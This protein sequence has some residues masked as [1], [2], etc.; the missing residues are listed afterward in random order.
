[1]RDLIIATES[2]MLALG[3]YLGGRV[4]PG[5]LLFLFGE[6]GVGK[7]TLAKGIANSLGVAETVTSPTFQLRKTYRGTMVFNHLDLYRI[8]REAELD[9][10]EPEEWLED[11]VTVVEWGQL[12]L[13]RLGQTYLEIM[14]EADPDDRRHIRFIAHGQRY[15]E[16]I[17]GVFDA[18]LGD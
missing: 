1:M 15:F 17:E 14:I 13:R 10:L 18:D 3:E 5:D 9:I 4:K 2:Q 12:L 6:L 11:G 16:L 8:K 7:T